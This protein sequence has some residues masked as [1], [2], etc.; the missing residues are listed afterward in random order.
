MTAPFEVSG[1]D[2]GSAQRHLSEDQ[3]EQLR[4]VLDARA[5]LHRIALEEQSSTLVSATN[6]VVD[7]AVTSNRELAEAFL[8]TIRD[9]A[10]E[11]EA[12]L[13]RLDEGTY[14]FCE[15]CGAEVPLERLEAL[16]ETRFCM[17]CPKHRGL[18]G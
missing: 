6:D 1:N 4:D 14:G 18:F 17:S 9:A 2:R 12:A 13:L 16:P 5:R 11:V 8:V 7:A 10:D 3:I 15:S